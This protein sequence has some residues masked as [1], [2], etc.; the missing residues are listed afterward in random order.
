MRNSESLRNREMKNR[1]RK[2]KPRKWLELVAGGFF[3]ITKN[4]VW[5]YEIL[6]FGSQSS[7]NTDC[8]RFFLI[9]MALLF[10]VRCQFA[11]LPKN[12]HFNGD[13]R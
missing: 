11:N 4:H 12:F 13:W 9:L 7:K 3:V 6:S 2:P 1:E 10:T 5:K 8:W